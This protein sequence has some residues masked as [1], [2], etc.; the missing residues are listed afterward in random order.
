MN[1]I[2]NV[3]CLS[4]LI[5]ILSLLA[6][7]HYLT[8]SRNNTWIV[9]I[10]RDKNKIEQPNTIDSNSLLSFQHYFILFVSI[11]IVY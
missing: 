11:R 8:L 4:F 9:Y 10:K 2:I 3:F 5:V 7:Y 1:V 6:I